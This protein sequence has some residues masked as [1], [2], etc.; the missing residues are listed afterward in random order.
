MDATIEQRRYVKGLAVRDKTITAA[1]RMFSLKGYGGSS[2]A[3]LAAAAGITRNQ[4]FH[5]F[6]SKE[7]LALECVVRARQNWQ[8]D[9]LTPAGIYPEPINRLVFIIEKLAEYH[10][11][12]DWPYARLLIS[13]GVNQ[14]D[15]PPAVRQAVQEALAE[16]FQALRGTLKELKCGGGLPGGAKAR[17]MAAQILATLLGAAALAAFG[18]T[19]PAEETYGSLR[20]LFAAAGN[21][22]LP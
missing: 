9:I 1:S 6:N 3:D 16:V 18:E 11:D 14:A 10:S 4:L 7:N 13:L 2:V 12:P 5:H 20:G 8:E 17:T 19:I 21:A 15:P 22:A